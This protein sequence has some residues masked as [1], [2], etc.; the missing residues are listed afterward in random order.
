MFTKDEIFARLMNG[1]S[2]DSIMAEMDSI[3]KAAAVE[4]E[5]AREAKK[6]EAVK[7]ELADATAEG[8][9]KLMVLVCPE[10]MKV[11]GEDKNLITGRML[12]ETLESSAKAIVEFAPMMEKIEKVCSC[13][14]KLGFDPVQAFID[15]D[16]KF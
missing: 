15:N 2:M 4:A 1:E 3:A 9:N 14:D 13:G 6:A 12:I 7:V 16:F 5:K 11:F 8:L 10:I